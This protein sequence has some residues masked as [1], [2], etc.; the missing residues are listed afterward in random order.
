MFSSIVKIN[1]E[2]MWGRGKGEISRI[3]ELSYKINFS[4]LYRRRS[5][6]ISA[7]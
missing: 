4:A 5:G 6:Q 1:T 3:K 2:W 7:A